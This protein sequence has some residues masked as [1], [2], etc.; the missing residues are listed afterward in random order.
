MSP[1]HTCTEY[2]KGKEEEGEG[3]RAVGSL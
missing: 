1:S 3:K 2:E